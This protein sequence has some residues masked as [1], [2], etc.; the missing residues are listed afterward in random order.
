[1][2]IPLIVDPPARLLV[3][4][5]A[6]ADAVEKIAGKLTRQNLVGDEKVVIGQITDLEE[7]RLVFVQNLI[8]ADWVVKITGPDYPEWSWAR[9]PHCFRLFNTPNC[10][11]PLAFMI[12]NGSLP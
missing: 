9:G 7:S 2:R 6:R 3:R 10:G 1:M 11:V 8:V 5:E 4:S 12:L